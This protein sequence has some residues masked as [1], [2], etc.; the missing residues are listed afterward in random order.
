[1]KEVTA[2]YVGDSFWVD[3]DDLRIILWRHHDGEMYEAVRREED[4]PRAL[5][6]SGRDYLR[7]LHTTFHHATSLADLSVSIQ[8]KDTSELFVSVSEDRGGMN[9]RY[10]SWSM[11]QQASPSTQAELRRRWCTEFA[12]EVC[13]GKR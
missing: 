1:M 8:E 4:K 2:A 10:D 11:V 3:G 12:V 5:T 7:T 13:I 9:L 6:C